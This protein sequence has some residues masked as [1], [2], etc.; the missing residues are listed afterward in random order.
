MANLF[1]ALEYTLQWEGGYSNDPIDHG[2]ETNYGITQITLNRYIKSHPG[3]KVP[4]RVKKLSV[5]DAE[6]IYRNE[7]WKFDGIR[8]QSIATKLFDMSVNMGVGTAVKML[9]RILGVD[10][11]GIFGTRTLDAVNGDDPDI[12]MLDLVQACI[13]RYE[14]IIKNDPTQERFRKGWMRRAKSMPKEE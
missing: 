7:Y 1:R 10:V 6:E 3:T 8:D 12:L 11:D 5:K 4:D 9:Q 14:S 13:N 2:G